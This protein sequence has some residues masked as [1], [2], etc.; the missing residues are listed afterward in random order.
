MFF[1]VIII[2][3]LIFIIIK[4]FCFEDW[5]YVIGKFNEIGGWVWVFGLIVG[6]FLIFLFGIRGIF[7]VFGVIGFFLFLWGKKIIWEVLFYIDRKIFGVYVGYVVEKFRYFLNMII[8]LLRFLM[9]GFGRF[10]FFF[11]L[12]WVGV[13][14]YFI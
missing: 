10:Y 1:I 7:I 5:D 12:F 4:V 14:F 9:K 13:M 2:F 11:F 8:Y 6:L 3:I